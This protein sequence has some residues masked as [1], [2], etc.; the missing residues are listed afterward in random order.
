MNIHFIR[1]KALLPVVALITMLHARAGAQAQLDKSNWE[2]FWSEEFDSKSSMAARWLP[3]LDVKTGDKIME[4]SMACISVDPSSGLATF[5]PV[6]D[7]VNAGM[8]RPVGLHYMQGG[9]R[10]TYE[11]IPGLINPAPGSGGGQGFLYGM[12]EIRAKLP[13]FPANGYSAF[14]MD[15]VTW[16]PEFDAFEYHSGTD[17]FFSS[18]H[19]RD[20]GVKKE[21]VTN[22]KPVTGGLTDDFHTWTIVWC[23]DKVSYFFD[24]RELKTE[25]D[26]AH[27]PGGHT[28]TD[29]GSAYNFILWQRMRIRLGST[30]L[31]LEDG[32]GPN[33]PIDGMVVDY[34]RVYKPAGFAA[35]YQYRES[36]HGNLYLW[37]HNYIQ[38]LYERS[39]YTTGPRRTEFPC[40]DN[41]DPRSDNDFVFMKRRGTAGGQNGMPEWTVAPNPSSGRFRLTSSASGDSVTFQ[42]ADVYGKIIDSQPVPDA[43]GLQLDLSDR[44]DGTYFLT[45]SNNTGTQHLKLV[46]Q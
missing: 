34:V 32:Q 4:A 16:P 11:E 5:R 1:T 18:T 15:A 22:Y 35:N 28:P 9:L 42:L 46:K 7:Y 27:I 19:W 43:S 21:C 14:W 38:P 25:T 24:G 10:S 39:P 31:W 13:R 6:I 3:E 8:S 44:M 41:P 40:H 29:A 30:L 2:L 45:I 23:P 20:A 12:F 36:V 33:T 26:P 37:L 17:Y